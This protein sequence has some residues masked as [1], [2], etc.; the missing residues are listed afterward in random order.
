MDVK[1]REGLVR[2]TIARQWLLDPPNLRFVLLIP[3]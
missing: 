2:V 1:Q 3:G